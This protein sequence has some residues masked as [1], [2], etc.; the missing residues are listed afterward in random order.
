MKVIQNRA[1]K[2]E[3]KMELQDVLLNEARYMAV[4]ADRKYDEVARKLVVME[5]D[6][7][8]AEERPALHEGVLTQRHLVAVTKEA[9]EVLLLGSVLF[10]D[11]RL[12]FRA[13]P[14]VTF[15]HSQFEFDQSLK[16]LQA[17]EEKEPKK[18]FESERERSTCREQHERSVVSFVNKL[19]ELL[20]LTREQHERGELSFNKHRNGHNVKTVMKMNHAF[21]TYSD[22][23]DK[24]EEEITILTGRLKEVNNCY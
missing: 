1:L 2:D 20:L 17:S 10:V 12:L 13:F 9:S 14:N 8:R 19:N 7:E 11:S 5:G 24:Y 16:T 15:G 23:E 21:K 22:K 18:C 4:E 6:L 3:E